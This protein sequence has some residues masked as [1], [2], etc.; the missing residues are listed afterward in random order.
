MAEFDEAEYRQLE[1]FKG[2]FE[3][4]DEISP[5]SDW[6]DDEVAV[7]KRGNNKRRSESVV[8]DTTASSSAASDVEATPRVRKASGKGKAK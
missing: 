2:V 5:D 1:Y 8:S 3:F 6:D 7:K 4:L